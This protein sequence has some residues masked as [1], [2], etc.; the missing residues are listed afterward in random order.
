MK[1]KK[2]LKKIY[3]G[4]ILVT[5]LFPS[6]MLFAD[7]I[8][9]GGISNPINIDSIQDLIKSILDI[10]IA[11]GTPIAVLFLVFSG[12]KFITAQGNTTKLTEARKYFMWTLVGIVILL[13]AG[14]LSEIVAGTI[15][16][17]GAGI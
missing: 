7:V 17:L 4:L 16:Q 1:I 3:Y 8:S 5:L 12:F 13:G 11:I 6:K 9:G 10:V 14:L 2:N 15:D